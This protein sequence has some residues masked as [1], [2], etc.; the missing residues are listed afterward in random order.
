M[1]NKTKKKLAKRD[2][3]LFACITCIMLYTIASFVLQ[4]VAKIEISSTLT[5]AYFSF[6]AVEIWQLARITIHKNKKS[7]NDESGEL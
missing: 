7:S 5:T 2:K 6:W 1:K 4:F 3:M